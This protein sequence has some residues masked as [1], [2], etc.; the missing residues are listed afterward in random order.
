MYVPIMILVVL[1]STLPVVNIVKFDHKNRLR[2]EIKTPKRH[3]AY[4]LD[5][6]A[7]HEKIVSFGFIWGRR[8]KRC[9]KLKK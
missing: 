6:N 3:I 5:S 9:S 8:L 2:T 7:M 4:I 1:C